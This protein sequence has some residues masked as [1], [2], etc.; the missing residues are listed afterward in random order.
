MLVAAGAKNMSECGIWSYE[1][2]LVNG[3]FA[4]VCSNMFLPWQPAL[5]LSHCEVAGDLHCRHVRPCP[6]HKA[7]SKFFAKFRLSITKFSFQSKLNRCDTTR[8][9]NKG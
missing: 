9:Q 8:C 6:N 4:N 3:G 5:A 1:F 2:G 7:V